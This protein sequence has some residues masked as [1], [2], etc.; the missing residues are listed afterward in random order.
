MKHAKLF[1]FI[2][3][4]IYG[5]PSKVCNSFIVFSTGKVIDISMKKIKS[6]LSMVFLHSLSLNEIIVFMFHYGCFHIRAF[7]IRLRLD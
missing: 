2:F 3:E 5:I 1:V 6:L 7:T 4:N